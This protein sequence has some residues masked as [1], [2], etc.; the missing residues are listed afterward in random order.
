M[1]IIIACCDKNFQNILA[2]EHSEMIVQVV[3]PK[4]LNID[5]GIQLYP[6][7]NMNSEVMDD[8][9]ERFTER[10]KLA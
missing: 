5:K 4:E 9:S 6:Y 10:F 1:G 2:S 8:F 3:Q 7:P